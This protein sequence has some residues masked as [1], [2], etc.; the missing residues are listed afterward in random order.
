MNLSLLRSLFLSLLLH[1]AAALGVYYLQSV[2]SVVPT[3]HLAFGKPAALLHITLAAPD[4]AAVAVVAIENKQTIEAS[5][6]PP[7]FTASTSQ[8][9]PQPKP[10]V[11]R[12]AVNPRF[13]S[14]HTLNNT[15]AVQTD[16]TASYT[17][18]SA[19]TPPVTTT[20]AAPVEELH[21]QPPLAA[22][23]LGLSGI[24]LIK[25]QWQQQQSP[26]QLPTFTIVQSSGNALLDAAAL[27]AIQ[28]HWAQY[29]NT[30]T[31]AE[32]TL[33]VVFS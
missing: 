14:T 31:T 27:Q 10:P 11:Q 2:G 18:Q 22:L 29:S 21:A 25:V 3:P 32:R 6:P 19:I 20:A 28:E 13:V 17:E 8:P 30:Q 1:G 33:K 7:A 16:Q 12:L 24:V 9:A 5:S 23:R 26:A 15:H 4:S